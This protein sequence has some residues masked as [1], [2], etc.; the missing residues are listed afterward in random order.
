[1]QA[2]TE[3]GTVVMA[4]A[5]G[6][7]L[8]AYASGAGAVIWVVGAQKI[9]PDLPAA[10]RRVE[11]YAYP[12][13]DRRARAAYG[14]PSIVAKLLIVSH[15]VLPARATLVLVRQTAGY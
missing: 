8:A 15:E 10:I 9:V 11:T 14:R 12:L 1:M 13:E 6:S 2:V 7:Q 3:D 5:S 4:S